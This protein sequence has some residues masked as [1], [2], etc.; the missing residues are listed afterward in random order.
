ME[1][2]KKLSLVFVLPFVVSLNANDLHQVKDTS[3]LS[4]GAL[5]QIAK[6]MDAKKLTILQADD[7][8]WIETK[9]GEWFKGRIKAMYNDKLEF[10]SEAIGNHTFDFEDIKQ[11]RSHQVLSV[12]IENYALVS[13]IVRLDNDKVTIIQGDAKY[14][15]QRDEIISF[16][17]DGKLERNYWSGKVT[18]SL[19]TRTGNS[20]QVDYSGAL[21]VK[22][23][24]AE[25]F[26]IVDYLGR[27]SSKD[28]DEIANDHRV[29][30][31]YDRYLTR[32]FF[33]TPLSAEYY[34]DRYKNIANQIT[35]GMGIGYTVFDTKELFWSLS[36]GPA[37]V[38]T[39]FDT[40]EEGEQKQNYSPA[41]EL[42]TRYSYRL[43]KVT[44]LK[45]DYKLTLSD[46][47]AGNYKHHTVV[48]FENKLLS[49]LDLD[50]TGVWDYV[51]NPQVDVDG[52]RPQKS[53]FEFLIGLGISF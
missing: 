13:G 43:T 47:K 49:W 11:I 24:T 18:L 33:W 37:L 50:L 1:N 19:D 53:D 48:K 36:G 51:L 34:T 9:S 38:Y 10:D 23:R 17:P 29:S 44:K 3:G 45:V 52:E 26:L 15:F 40:V 41:L 7:A 30:L 31:K 20:N 27:I 8:D 21:S 14:Q 42:S 6:D 32:Y 22:R 25:A 39:E 2:Y 5:R 12:N 16:A 35:A 46:N 4:S 28:G